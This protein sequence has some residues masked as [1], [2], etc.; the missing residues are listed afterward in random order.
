MTQKLQRKPP[1]PTATT[2]WTRFENCSSFG[3]FIL[4]SSQKKIN[5]LLLRSWCPDRVLPQARKYIAESLGA[6][7]AEGV[8]LNLEEMW[9]ESTPRVPM[10][11]FLSMGSDPT[12]SVDMLARKHDLSESPSSS[13]SSLCGLESRIT[14]T[15]CVNA[16]FGSVSM[17][18]GQEVHARRLISQCHAQVRRMLEVYI[19]S[20]SVY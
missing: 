5:L 14:N 15:F 6:K 10:I 4:H 3:E 2:L 12:N 13:S 16:A 20:L 11:C 7:Y 18:Q 19:Q 1:F 8:I 9:Q 17:G